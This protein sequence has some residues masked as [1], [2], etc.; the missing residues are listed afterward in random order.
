[1][2]IKKNIGGGLTKLPKDDRD[3]SFGGIF[4]YGDI[5]SLPYRYII[6]NE[7]K[8][9]NQDVVPNSDL[10]TAFA[11]TSLSEYQENVELSPEYQFM[12]TKLIQGVWETWGA[13]LRSA[14]KSLVKFGSLE[15]SQSPY[16]LGK[17]GRD[18]VANWNNWEKGLDFYAK[19]HKKLSYFKVEPSFNVDTFDAIR[20]ALFHGKEKMQAVFTGVLWRPEWT[21]AHYGVLPKKYGRD[22][23]GHAVLAIG[24]DN[25]DGEEKIILQLSNGRN[26]GNNGLFYAS[27]DIVNQE[28][29]YG[30]FVFEDLPPEQAKFLSEKKLTIKSRWWVKYISKLYAKITSSH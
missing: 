21:R 13:D 25:I 2:S 7:P 6:T 27:R 26:I 12:K 4:G 20:L 8:I 19:V 22:G 5:K 30:A 17:D 23:F 15:Q 28:F 14:C 24:W 10:C 1:M 16:T 11:L 29:T 9:K 18:K 3:F